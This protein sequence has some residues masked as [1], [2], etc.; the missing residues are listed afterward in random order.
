MD[1]QKM[2][3]VGKATKDAEIH[4]SEGKTAYADFTVAVSTAKEQTTFFPIR[5]FGKLAETCENVKK[6]VKV[7][8]DGKLDISEYTDKD[9]QKRTSFRILAD[10]YRV[11]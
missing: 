8:V 10:A 6:G 2:I 5:A 7:L 4:H 3:I 1:Y 9:G 11:L